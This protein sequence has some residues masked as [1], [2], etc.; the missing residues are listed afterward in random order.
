MLPPIEPS[1]PSYALYS[2]CL[3]IQSSEAKFRKSL[4]FQLGRLLGTVPSSV[5]NAENLTVEMTDLTLEKL[6]NPDKKFQGRLQ[7]YIALQK[8][9]AFEGLEIETAF[10]LKKPNNKTI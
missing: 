9:T 2:A 10:D 1:D 5:L 3:E 8:T 7:P 4:I 6:N